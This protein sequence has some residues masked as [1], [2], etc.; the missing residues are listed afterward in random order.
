MNRATFL[1]R[2][3]IFGTYFLGEWI[4]T[5]KSENVEEAFNCLS[6]N[7]FKYIPLFLYCGVNSTAE[8]NG[9]EKVSLNDVIEEV[10]NLGGVASEKVQS[11][12]KVFTDSI[13]MNLGNAKGESKKP[14]AKV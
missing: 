2:E 14:R 10:D 9:V 7:P 3:I 6:K 11:I 8:L 13:T 4:E 5:T 12:L 1:N